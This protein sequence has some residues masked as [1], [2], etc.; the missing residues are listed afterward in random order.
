MLQF[1]TWIKLQIPI[2]DQ[3]TMWCNCAYLHYSLQPRNHV[4]Q[5]QLTGSRLLSHV[6]F[7]I[8]ISEYTLLL[9]LAH[10]FYLSAVDLTLEISIYPFWIIESLPP[11]WMWIIGHTHC[12]VCVCM[13][14]VWIGCMVFVW[15]EHRAVMRCASVGWQS[16]T[17]N[18]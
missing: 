1:Y 2:V 11:M 16:H 14:F 9:S 6:P 12:A 18:Y 17:T 13:C 5:W 15:S 7:F 3:K 10:S 4:M 8:N